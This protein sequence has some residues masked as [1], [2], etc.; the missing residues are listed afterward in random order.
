[1]QTV[2]SAVTLYIA[3][4]NADCA[5]MDQLIQDKAIDKSKSTRDA[6]DQEFQIECDGTE[7]YCDLRRSRQRVRDRRRHQ[8]IRA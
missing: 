7:I 2:R 4:N 3:T 6:W 5:T 1:M 8:V